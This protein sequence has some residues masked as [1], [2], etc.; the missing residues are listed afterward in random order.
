MDKVLE[1]YLETVKLTKLRI[2]TRL[3]CYDSEEVILNKLD[4]IWNNSAEQE[5]EAIEKLPQMWWFFY[6]NKVSELDIFP[7]AQ[8]FVKQE[9]HMI[10]PSC[11]EGYPLKLFFGGVVKAYQ[12][13]LLFY[14]QGNDELSLMNEKQYELLQK[15]YD[16][17]TYQGRYPI[18]RKK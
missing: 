6:D 16:F 1:Y 7:Y 9:P 4:T 14:I 3:L 2:E 13:E 12:A 10:H 18:F 8:Y 17:V 15:D 5:I 11:V